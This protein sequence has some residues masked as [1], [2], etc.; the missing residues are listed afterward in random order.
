MNTFIRR[1]KIVNELRRESRGSFVTLY[2][3]LV[4]AA[5]DT[6][7]KHNGDTTLSEDAVKS[8]IRAIVKERNPAK[9]A[10]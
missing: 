6:S 5:G 10:G 2:R 4:E 7:A 3:A 8:R 1:D 9:E